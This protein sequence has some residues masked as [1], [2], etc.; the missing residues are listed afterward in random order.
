MY[1]LNGYGLKVAGKNQK[2]TKRSL[3]AKHCCNLIKIIP[4]TI[5]TVAQIQT[6]S[7]NTYRIL[8][9]ATGEELNTLGHNIEGRMAVFGVADNIILGASYNGVVAYGVEAE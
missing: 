6:I 7:Y 3:V 2:V 8:D 1:H 9:A 5:K 4:N